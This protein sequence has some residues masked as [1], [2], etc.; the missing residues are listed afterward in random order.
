MPLDFVTERRFCCQVFLLGLQNFAWKNEAL[1]F[2]TTRDSRQ[3]YRQPALRSGVRYDRS[4]GAVIG[5]QALHLDAEGAFQL[6]KV[7]TLFLDEKC[8]SQAM[9]RHFGRCG[10]RDE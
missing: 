9:C 10:R 5:A 4:G 1:R 7:G 2:R 3:I 8:G 6:E